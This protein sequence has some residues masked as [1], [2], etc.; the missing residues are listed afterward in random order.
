MKL[1]PC[2]V[3]LAAVLFATCAHADGS[4]EFTRKGKTVK[5]T[6]ATAFRFDDR[7]NVSTR[8][9]FS[10]QPIDTAK[11]VAAPGG[12]VLQNA[13]DQV[14]QSGYVA[15]DFTDAGE[16][17]TIGYYGPDGIMGNVTENPTFTRHDAKHVTGTFR[18][19]DEDQKAGDGTGYYDLKFDIDVVAPAAGGGFS[20]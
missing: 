6:H 17:E 20:Y 11:A 14:K 18:T 8:I 13:I 5:F 1:N 10:T 3:F 7:P 12:L 4:G 9:I 2:I 15:L 16:V 19:A